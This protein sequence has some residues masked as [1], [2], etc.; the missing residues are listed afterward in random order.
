VP[1]TLHGKRLKHSLAVTGARHPVQGYDDIRAGIWFA[2]PSTG[3]AAIA[4]C[5]LTSFG[6]RRADDLVV[7]AVC[8]RI[9]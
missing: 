3:M 2:V 9:E 6:T 8:S 1:F 4:G 7:K 5:S